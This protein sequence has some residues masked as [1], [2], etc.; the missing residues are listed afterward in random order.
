MNYQDNM[1]DCGFSYNEK[2]LK[3]CRII[4][5]I[6]GEFSYYYEIVEGMIGLMKFFE[7]KA[8][9]LRQEIENVKGL[10]AAT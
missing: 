8:E 4:L 9:K 7:E 1:Y 6:F 10:E 2:T 3:G 5:G